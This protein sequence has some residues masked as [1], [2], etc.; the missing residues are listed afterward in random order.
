ME[1]VAQFHISFLDLLE[2]FFISGEDP[3]MTRNQ[4]LAKW[5][6]VPSKTLSRVSLQPL[7]SEWNVP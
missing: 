6:V 1:H 3:T 2:Q 7:W 5:P 4:I